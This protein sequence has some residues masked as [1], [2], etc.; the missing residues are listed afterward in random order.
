MRITLVLCALVVATPAFAED[1]FL[2]ELAVTRNY[3]L[4]RPT[5]PEPT[6]DG[7]AVLFLRTEP[8]SPVNS[9]YAFDVATG[10][11]RVLLTPEQ[12]L[13]GAEEKLSAA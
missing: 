4:G 1:S 12:I 13:K 8:R 10:Q 2:R 11:T 5:H 3:S 7:S 9:L 6:A